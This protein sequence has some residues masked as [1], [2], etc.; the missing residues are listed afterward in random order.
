MAIAVKHL[1]IGLTYAVWAGSGT[2]L[3]ALLGMIW[4][5]EA[6]SALRLVGLLFIV[7][8]VISLNLSVAK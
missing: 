1:E 7:L 6:A 2:A 5:H 4:F 3:T 8:G